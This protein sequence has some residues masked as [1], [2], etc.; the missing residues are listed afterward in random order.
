MA[1]N[2][3]ANKKSKG[4]DLATYHGGLTYKQF[5]NANK[6]GLELNDMAWAGRL[7]SKMP[8]WNK[9]LSSLTT[10]CFTITILSLFVLLTSVL[11]RTPALLIGVYPDGEIV[12]FPRLL[13]KNGQENPLDSSYDKIC[14]SIDARVGRKWQVDNSKA[15]SDKEAVGDI[16][17][18][19]KYHTVED[20]EKTLAPQSLQPV[21][22]SLAPNPA[23]QSPAVPPSY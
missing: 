3:K 1:A 6:R 16:T 8:Y 4:K 5:R 23:S 10:I 18:K 15:Q 19:T 14:S 13:D 12:C 17:T 20:V 7:Y 11:M 21:S 22:P 2:N 9:K